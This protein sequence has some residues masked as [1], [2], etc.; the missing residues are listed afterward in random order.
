MPNVRSDSLFLLIQ[1]MSKSEK[2]FFKLYA[3]RLRGTEEKKFLRLFDAVEKQRSHDDEKL[4]DLGKDFSPL[5]LS[6]MKAHLYGQL[7]KCLRLCNT[8]QLK[9]L[10]LNELLDNARILYNKCL[11]RDCGKLLEKAK[12]AAMREDRS[13]MLLEILGLEKL[14]IT[15]TLS[16]NNEER[17][18]AIVLE[19]EEAA[20]RVRH[21][22]IFSNLALKLNSYYVR[23]GFIRNRE[24][25]RKVSL[26]FKKS[27]P[28]YREAGLSFHEKLH[29]YASCVGYYFYV[30]DFNKAKRFAT[31]WVQLFEDAPAYII[32]E[33]EMYIKGLNS[34]LVVQNKLYSYH[35]FVATMKKLVALKRSKELLLTEN[36]NLT[37]FKAIYVHEINR[38][39]MLG[40]FRSGTRIVAKLEPELNR[41]IPKLDKSSVLLFYYKIACLYFGSGNYRTAL[42]WLY[43]INAE[44]E[45]LR[46]DIF[47][48]TRI[49]ML[50]CHYEMD[51]TDLLESSIRS[52]YRYFLKK[53][54]ITKYKL[55]ILEFLKQLFR[56]PSEKMLKKNF[57]KLKDRML[58]LENNKF[59]KRAFLYFDIISWLESKIQGRGVE[60][61]IREKARSRIG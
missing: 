39:F 11:Y 58:L 33:T 60:E 23:S 8:S 17:V 21:I 54:H 22:N 27:L 2:R 31:K 12:R 1:S 28:A 26:Y 48:F 50:I 29:L 36:L 19:V 51:N 25:L 4:L 20:S 6:N 18:N 44:K 32:N 40:E 41:F 35:D 59:E 9:E 38:H 45:D 43:R 52:S 10:Q 46:E 16:A 49:L 7:L 30:Q 5:Q 47:S 13:V 34:L 42:K 37:L 57:A 55:I 14:L 53:G 24:D 3:S 56:E 61:I 15:K